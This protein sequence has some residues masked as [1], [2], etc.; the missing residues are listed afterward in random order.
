MAPVCLQT[1]RYTCDAGKRAQT[2][3][4]LCSLDANDINVRREPRDLEPIWTVMSV[5]H[6]DK[7]MEKNGKCSNQV[8]FVSILYIS[9]SRLPLLLPFPFQ[10]HRVPTAILNPPPCNRA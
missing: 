7:P 8:E 3:C 2:L 1:L 9:L 10:K 4:A 5:V 6:H